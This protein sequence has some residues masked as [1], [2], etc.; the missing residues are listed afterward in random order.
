MKKTLVLS[1]AAMMLV[2]ASAF[3]KESTLID[4]SLLDSDIEVKALLA[5]PYKPSLL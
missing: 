4:F 3:A 1:A 5:A 2:G